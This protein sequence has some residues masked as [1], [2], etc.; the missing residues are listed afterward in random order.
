[1]S[2]KLIEKAVMKY[3]HLRDQKKQITDKHKEELLPYNEAMS[4]IENLV[5]A[6]LQKQ[7]ASNIKTAAGTV[8][9]STVVRPKITDWKILRPFIL[10]NDLIDMMTL[11]LA[12]DAVD[13]FRESTGDLPPGVVITTEINARFKK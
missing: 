4:K 10:E 1:M 5:L 12:P 7:G 2:E 13:Q 3:I 8:Y 9:T 6:L 11:K